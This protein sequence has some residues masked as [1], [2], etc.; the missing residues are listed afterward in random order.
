MKDEMKK[1]VPN[2]VLIDD[3]MIRTLRERRAS[4]KQDLRMAVLDEYPALKTDIQVSASGLVYRM[5]DL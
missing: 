5:H 4:V 2:F 3:R 1:T